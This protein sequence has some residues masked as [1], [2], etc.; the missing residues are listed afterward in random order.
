L[1]WLYLFTIGIAI[2][3][4]PLISYI[5]E[6][7]SDKSLRRIT[8]RRGRADNLSDSLQKWVE[9][10][11]KGMSGPRLLKRSPVF[12][13]VIVALSIA[14]FMFGTIGM[15]NPAAGVMLAVAGVVFPEQVYHNREQLRR[16]KIL[17]QMGA[18][19]RLFAEEYS[20]T[21]HTV[22]AL[23]IA[24]EKM[25]NP[26]KGILEKAHKG[27]TSGKDADYVLI[28]L[29]KDLDNEY[30]RMFVQLLRLS[31]EDQA[32]KPLFRKLANRI[33]S[34]QGLIQ[35]NKVELTADRILSVA[36]NIAIVPA[37]LAIHRY[38]PDANEFFTT[39]L[40]GKILVTVC[41]ASAVCAALIDRIANKGG[42]YD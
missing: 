34:Q 9:R 6:K 16:E 17:E 13:V 37:Y 27:L 39:T 26:I 12:F 20:E 24:A 42:S 18:A 14:G 28:D 29:A 3:A 19:V 1:I 8:F 15:K 40:A 4:I 30:G 22:K 7:L 33:S 38:V 2:A 35:K 31:F 21:P 5:I 10:A 25:P 23:G 41:I 11:Q 32:I 36:L